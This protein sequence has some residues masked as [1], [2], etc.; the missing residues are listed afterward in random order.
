MCSFNMGDFTGAV[1]AD[2]DSLALMDAEEFRRNA[3][4]AQVS[5]ARNLLAAGEADGALERG[6]EAV[7]LLRQVRS[8]RW[9]AHLATFHND[10]LAL[11][12]HGSPAFADHYREATA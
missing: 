3:F 7:G 4:A 2:L 1:E 8:A 6:H 10:V 5:L 9:S 11:A 12:P